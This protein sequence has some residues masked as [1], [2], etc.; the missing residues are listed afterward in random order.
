MTRVQSHFTTEGNIHQGLQLSADHKLMH[1]IPISTLARAVSP[2]LCCTLIPGLVSCG[3]IQGT[4]DLLSTGSRTVVEPP[5]AT[6]H[7][8]LRIST[9][10]MTLVQPGS[11]CESMANPRGGVAV[12]ASQLH[13]GARGVTNQVRGVV[14]DAPKGFVSG[15][16]RLTAGEPVTVLYS[17]T[18]PV[19][20]YTYNCR[21]VRS[22]VPLAGAHYQLVTPSDASQRRCSMAVLQLAP[23]PLLVETA[24]APK[25]KAP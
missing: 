12:M 7:A 15:E 13:L 9:D 23:A 21:L 4:M 20:D 11:A 18:W 22:F 6:P 8:L 25:C 10:G 19:G 1:H 16:L 3:Q 14:G 17:V 24:A 2:L 5:E